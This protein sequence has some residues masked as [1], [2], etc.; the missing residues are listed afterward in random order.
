MPSREPS[1]TIT[2]LVLA[3]GRGRRLGGQDKGLLPLGRQPATAWLLRALAPQT[4][5]L[6]ISANRHLDQYRA[7]GYPVV[8]DR[9]GDYAGP[10]AGLL[11]G[12]EHCDTEYLLS[13]PCDAPLLAPDYARRML[14]ALQAA[15][16]RLCVAHDGEH[17]Q[18]V[19]LLLHRE[20]VGEL[21][22][23]L[24]AGQRKTRDWVLALAPA[25]ADFS[26]RPEQFRNMNTPEEQA[27]L[28]ALLSAAQ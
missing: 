15:G 8:T 22:A 6:L 11:A 25:V 5:A 18:P 23:A 27:Q 19:H 2:G 28:Q 24:A 13:V 3:G 14:A 21:R 10:L 4:D 16:A 17:L 12:L 20:L 26:D 9:T 7:F 1:A